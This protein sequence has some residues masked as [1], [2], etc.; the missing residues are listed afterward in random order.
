MKPFSDKNNPNIQQASGNLGYS[1]KK[2]IAG[3]SPGGI[4]QRCGQIGEATLA[5]RQVVFG[6]CGINHM[7]A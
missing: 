1:I 5:Q 7:I 4:I 6:R 2:I 3:Y